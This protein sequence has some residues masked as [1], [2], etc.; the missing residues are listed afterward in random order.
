[1]DWHSV[2]ELGRCLGREAE[3]TTRLEER[4][5]AAEGRLLKVEEVVVLI[6]RAGLLVV[7]WGSALLIVL[8]GDKDADVVVGVIKAIV[9]KL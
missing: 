9:S 7:L 6:R 4:V 3:R 8:T 5:A 1:M 2:L